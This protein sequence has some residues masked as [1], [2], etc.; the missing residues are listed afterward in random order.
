MEVGE[1]DIPAEGKKGVVKLVEIPCLPR[2]MKFRLY[3]IHTLLYALS[4]RELS[5][6]PG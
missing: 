6:R 2:D 1:D 4:S 5:A 3:F